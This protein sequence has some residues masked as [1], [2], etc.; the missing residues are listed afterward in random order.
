L[1]AKTA[2]LRTTYKYKIRDRKIRLTIGQ[3]GGKIEGKG[4]F[5]RTEMRVVCR[6][7]VYVANVG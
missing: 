7:V 1:N 6:Q 2:K 5:F 4:A 3:M